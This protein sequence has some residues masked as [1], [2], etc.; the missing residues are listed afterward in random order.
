M[1]FISRYFSVPELVN[2]FWVWGETVAIKALSIL[3]LLFYSVMYSMDEF[4]RLMY[5]LAA[6]AIANVLSDM[7][8]ELY[9]QRNMKLSDDITI[10]T[11]RLLSL[12]ILFSLVAFFVWYLIVFN[13]SLTFATHISIAISLVLRAEYVCLARIKFDLLTHKISPYIISGYIAAFFLKI[14]ISLEGYDAQYIIAIDALYF[15]FVGIVSVC[16]YKKIYNFYIYPIWL[17]P[18]LIKNLLLAV[19]PFLISS[20]ALLSYTKIDQVMLVRMLGY[21][22]NAVYGLASTMIMSS[23]FI[24]SAISSSLFPK[25]VDVMASKESVNNEVIR[26]F[27]IGYV[28]SALVLIALII[29]FHVYTIFNESYRDSVFIFYL[30]FIGVFPATLGIVSNKFLVV[31]GLYNLILRRNIVA[32]IMNILFNIV[33]IPLYGGVGAALSSIIALTYVGVVSNL[34]NEDTSCL[35]RMQIASLKFPVLLRGS[36]R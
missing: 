23:L 34:L 29:M 28:V 33:L 11:R 20:L 16:L 10:Y 5:Y 17:R 25:M 15:A 13:E 19:F 1:K 7:G 6:F 18:A 4:G 2:V 27:E 36:I 24:V 12:R 30:V 35:F 22:E 14:I 21:S 31:K 26:Q 32:G 3:F 9:Q 8:M